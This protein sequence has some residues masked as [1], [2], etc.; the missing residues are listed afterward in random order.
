LTQ[1]TK[2]WAITAAVILL[3]DMAIVSPP[4]F[5]A[6]GI[7][8]IS[9][10]IYAFFSGICHQLPDRT[11]HFG[12]LPMA[13]C[14]RCFGVY[15][16]LLAGV[17]LYALFRRIDDIEPLPR[18]WLILSIVPMAVDWS[19]TVFGIWENTFATRFLTGGILGF[20]CG[21][22]IL[23]AL[24]EITRNFTPALNNRPRNNR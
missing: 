19:L 8:S 9:S 18:K 14:S 6:A 23:P 17:V 3:W 4:I 7:T 13:V 5:T 11:F 16:G 10:V 12:E 20:A 15:F 21:V 24:V 1:A 2:V 22:Y